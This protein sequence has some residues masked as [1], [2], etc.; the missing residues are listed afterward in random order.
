VGRDADVIVVGAG[1]TGAAAA[2]QLA[3]RG[4]G[5]LVLDRAGALTG[6]GGA[7]IFQAGDCELAQHYRALQSLRLW[8]ELEAATGAA[9]LTLTGGVAHGDTDEVD[10]LAWVSDVAGSAGRWLEPAEAVERWPGIRYSSKVFFHPLCGRLDASVAADALRCA[11]RDH[12]AVLRAGEAVSAVGV[13]RENEVEVRTTARTY[14]ARR[15]VIAAGAA[16]G[17]L[18][19]ELVPLPPLCP[20]WEESVGFGAVRDELAWPVFRHLLSDTELAIEG[21]PADVRGTPVPGGV[22]VGFAVADADEAGRARRHSAL[23]RYVRQR[24]PGLDPSS[25]SAAERR[26]TATRKPVLRQ[27]GPVVV[28]AG[29]SGGDFGFLPVVGRAIAELSTTGNS[30]PSGLTA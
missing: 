15:V 25:V 14:R 5:V 10:L 21:Y 6:D 7:V 13:F 2:W 29:F 28:A 17:E 19:G 8:R 24:L 27:V 18:A 3:S 9:F 23:R 20:T 11:A 16:T 26:Y 12:S 22:S 4:I 1:C 30:R